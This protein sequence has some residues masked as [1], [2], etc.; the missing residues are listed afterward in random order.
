MF[1]YV[2]RTCTTNWTFFGFAEG[3]KHIQNE[4]FQNL[5]MQITSR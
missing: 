5:I 4:P 2:C 3:I 1:I